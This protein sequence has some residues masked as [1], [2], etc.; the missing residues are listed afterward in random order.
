MKGKFKFIGIASIAVLA[1][2]GFYLWGQSDIEIVKQAQAAGGAKYT[3]NTKSPTGAMEPRDM[4]FPGTEKLASGEMRIVAA[5]TGMPA[6]RRGQAATCWLVELGNGDKFLFDI[7]SG[8][9]A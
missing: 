2:M 6:Q 5:G 4:Y 1:A 9:G 3:S 8:S 7:G